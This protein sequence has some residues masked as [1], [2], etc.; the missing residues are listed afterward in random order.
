MIDNQALPFNHYQLYMMMFESCDIASQPALV[1]AAP[2]LRQYL[3]PFHMTSKKL[4]N[5]V[6]QS[7]DK[8]GTGAHLQGLHCQS[9]LTELSSVYLQVGPWVSWLGEGID[10]VN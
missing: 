4:N 5:N 7:F 1:V 2:S 8:H 9:L 6:N 3:V 10:F